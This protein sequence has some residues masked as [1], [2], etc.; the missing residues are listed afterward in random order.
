MWGGNSFLLFYGF[1]PPIPLIGY[2]A[3]GQGCRRQS[4]AHGA[5][6]LSYLSAFIRN[7]FA[8]ERI[9]Y[10]YGAGAFG[11]QGCENHNGLYAC[12]EPWPGGGSQ[13][14]GLPVKW[15]RA[16]YADPYKTPSQYKCGTEAV[17]KQ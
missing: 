9:G 1:P 4:G 11:S 8:G 15:K 17:Y 14:G 5:R 2:S 13:S 16:Y 3:R 10:P 12:A 6:H 7:P